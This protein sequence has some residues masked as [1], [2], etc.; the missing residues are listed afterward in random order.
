MTMQSTQPPP[1]S[2]IDLN[3]YLTAHSG[4]IALM[5]MIATLI[6]IGHWRNWFYPDGMKREDGSP[7]PRSG[8]FN[9]NKAIGEFVGIPAFIIAG[10]LCL[11]YGIDLVLSCAVVAFCSFVG[12]AFVAAT[13]EK[14]RDGAL[15]VVLQAVTS[16]IPGARK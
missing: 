14:A 1:R 3:S 2:E 6:T 9:L 5:L 4:D 15:G 13:F 7:D 10:L 11:G 12:W 8:Y 16:W